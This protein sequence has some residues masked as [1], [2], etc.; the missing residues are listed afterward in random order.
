MPFV[1]IWADLESAILS[2]SKSERERHISY[3]ITYIWDFKIWYKWTYL[4]S[5]NRVT[6]VENKLYLILVM[7]YM[8]KES[9]NEWIY[10]YAPDSLCCTAETNTTL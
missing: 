1:V 10:V 8:G 7:T 9:K 2:E 3:N 6:D 4:K 5:R